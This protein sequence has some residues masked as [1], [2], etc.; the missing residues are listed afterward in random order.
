M[1]VKMKK[2]K[3]FLLKMWLRKFHWNKNVRIQSRQKWKI[4]KMGRQIL[5]TGTFKKEEDDYVF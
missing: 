3:K 1:S 2:E 4:Y 5:K